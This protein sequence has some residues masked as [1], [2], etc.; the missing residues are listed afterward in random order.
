MTTP[1]TSSQIK[2]NV[3][4]REEITG[5]ACVAGE[6]S[7]RVERGSGVDW[8]IAENCICRG[9]VLRADKGSRL[10]CCLSCIADQQA[11]LTAACGWHVSPDLPQGIQG[12]FISSYFFLGLHFPQHNPSQLIPLCWLQKKLRD[13]WQGG[14]KPEVVSPSWGL[15][16]LRH[17]RLSSGQTGNF[18]RGVAENCCST[19][20]LIMV[21]T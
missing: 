18:G 20:S 5:F 2:V 13:W 16:C 12:R 3:P 7:T 6:G 15:W 11:K 10:L 21:E 14:W 17:W 8:Q 19:S 1:S 9:P 4:W